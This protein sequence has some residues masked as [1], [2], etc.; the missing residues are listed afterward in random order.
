MTVGYGLA[1]SSFPDPISSSAGL[2]IHPQGTVEVHIPN[3]I[4][5]AHTLRDQILEELTR[6][7][8]DESSRFGIQLA[9]DEA[10]ANA[11]IHGN[12][13]RT[14]AVLHI[15]Y[16]ITPE[17]AYLCIS[18]EGEGFDP[19]AVQ[20]PTLNENIEQ[21]SGRGLFLMRAY[22]T[23]IEFN[24]KGSAVRMIHCRHPE[25]GPPPGWVDKNQSA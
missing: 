7:G 24:K 4:Q 21:P 13:R 23:S 22:M 15:A 8:Y 11:V 1:F 5:E 14:D 17:A 12:R 2:P 10:V 6:A 18:D 20:D 25:K 3:K 19:D 9:F 16:C